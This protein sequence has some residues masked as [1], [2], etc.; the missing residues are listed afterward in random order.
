MLATSY[1]LSLSVLSLLFLPTCWV[2]LLAIGCTASPVEASVNVSGDGMAAL[3][4]RI[5]ERRQPSHTKSKAAAKPLRSEELAALAKELCA[6]QVSCAQDSSHSCRADFVSIGKLRETVQ[7]EP[8][9]GAA[10][11]FS[12]LHVTRCGS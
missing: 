7:C 12:D 2:G 11:Q 1:S 6:E 10:H 5:E 8:G 9:V 3:L 4:R